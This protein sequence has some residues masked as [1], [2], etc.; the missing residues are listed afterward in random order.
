MFGLVFIG[1]GLE[2]F[3]LA[4]EERV[5]EGFSIGV[6]AMV[7]FSLPLV[8]IGIRIFRNGFPRRLEPTQN[9]N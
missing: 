9:S 8:L 2:F 1:F 6:V 3:S 4:V 7:A 5:K